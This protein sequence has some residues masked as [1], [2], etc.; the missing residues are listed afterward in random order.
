MQQAIIALATNALDAMV[1]NGVLTIVAKNS[2]NKVVVEVLD[3]G[4]GIDL[5]KL[6]QF[7]NGI[8]NIRR[9]MS[10]IGGELLIT[11]ENGTVTVLELPLD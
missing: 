10:T 2:A 5:S 9:R 8:H 7:G 3:N 11:N 4:V 6:R 1:N